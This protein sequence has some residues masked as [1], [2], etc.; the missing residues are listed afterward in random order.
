MSLSDQLKESARWFDAACDDMSAACILA[1][2]GMHATACFHAQQSLEKAF[3]GLLMAHGTL[4]KTHSIE[5]LSGMVPV[6]G[7]WD[8]REVIKL[9]RFYIA[10]RYPEALPSGSTVRKHF[11]KKDA[12]EAITIAQGGMDLLMRWAASLGVRVPDSGI[13][14]AQAAAMDPGQSHE[15]R[16]KEPDR[17]DST[18]SS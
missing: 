2:R 1:E 18:P 8:E 11:T 14:A 10:A 13:P 9:D 17:E 4:P 6:E 5:E 12:Q 16:D 3:K 7:G 15:M